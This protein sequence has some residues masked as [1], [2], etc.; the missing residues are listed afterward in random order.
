MFI[1][2]KVHSKT[3]NGKKVT[4]GGIE[5]FCWKIILLQYQKHA[6]LFESLSDELK[7]RFS[8]WMFSY[9]HLNECYIIQSA[10]RPDFC[11]P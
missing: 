7:N 2:T 6:L 4:H 8:T 5:S 1:Y 10:E 9:Q 3:S 11:I